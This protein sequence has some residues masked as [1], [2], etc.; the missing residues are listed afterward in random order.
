M[1][2]FLHKIFPATGEVLVF[3]ILHFVHFSDSL[4]EKRF[5]GL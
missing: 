4:M 1:V 5:N 3:F 2:T